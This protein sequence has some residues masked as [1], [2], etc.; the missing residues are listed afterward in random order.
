MMSWTGRFCLALLALL[1]ACKAKPEVTSIVLDKPLV[2]IG[3]F[4]QVSDVVELSDGRLAVA[5]VGA[6]RFLLVDQSGESRE[7][8]EHA[9]SIWP[10][11]GQLDKHKIPGYVILFPGDTIA[12]VDFGAERTT[13]WSSQGEPLTAINPYRVGGHNQPLVYDGEGNGYKED[14]RSV[15]GGLEPGDQVKLDSLN[16]LRLARSDT[17][18]DTVARLKLPAWG[19]GQFGE[20]RKIV[21]TIFAGR[22]LFG[23]LP[24]GTIWVARISNN[25][26]DW[27]DPAGKWSRGPERPYEKI[28]VTE[29][30]KQS[31]LASMR[32]RMVQ[33]GAPAGVEIKYPFADYKPA[34]SAGTTGRDGRVW[35]QRSRAGGDSIPVWDLI[36]RDG[37]Q[38]KTVQL[39]KGTSLAGFGADGTIYLIQRVPGA[40]QQLLKYK[41]N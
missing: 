22:D 1:A 10:P 34:F 40:G 17:F 26:V 7:I 37:Q 39:P 24:D 32:A 23:V 9:D 31:F 41:V 8:G 35:L 2:T 11:D 21:S 19:D 16:V 25:A 29:A 13:L 28:A 15:L 33:V 6:K 30:D 27:R 18:A 3:S 38:A 5:D 20:Q 14:V 12:L 36:G 4:Q